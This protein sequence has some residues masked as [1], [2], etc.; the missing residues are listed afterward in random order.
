ML[1]IALVVGVWGWNLALT[2]PDGKTR[3]V[4]LEGGTTI[5]QAPRGARIVIDGGA[6]PSAV[7]ATLGQRMPFWDRAVDLLVLTEADDDHVAALVTVL[8]RYEVRQIL[9][10]NTPAKPT[11]AY[12]KWREL[13]ASRRV[14]SALAHTG[15]YVALDHTVELEIVS[16]REET[17]SATA[18]LRAGNV[19]FLFAESASVDEQTT[20]LKSG[21]DLTS[22]VLIAP[23]RITNDFVD[24]V[25]PQFAILFGGHTARDKLSS[26]LLAAL[27]RATIL[28]TSERGTIEMIVDGQMLVVRTAR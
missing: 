9:E 3:V 5:V 18:R 16:A 12:S 24:A 28:Q 11:A 7:L 4:F 20:L 2:A 27:A 1:G 13:I 25:N 10:V 14:P 23:R 22:I 26:D 17:A 6:Q 8:E 21:D 19:A 15:L